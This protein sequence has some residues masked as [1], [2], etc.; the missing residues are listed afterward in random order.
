MKKLF[1]VL[2]LI[3]FIDVSISF[4]QASRLT[5]FNSI[6]WFVYVGD[7]QLTDKWAIHTEYQWRRVGWISQQQQ[8]L[9]R[10]GL[11][12]TLSER[13][14]VSGGYTYF[15]S[16]RYGTYPEVA[17]RPE[18]EHRI[19]QDVSLKD[20]LGKLQLTHRLRLEQRWLGSRNE[21][22][23]SPVQEWTYQNRIRYQISAEFP[24]QGSTTDDGE[25]YLNAFD[26]LFIGFGQAVEDNVFNQNR[27][28]GGIGYQFTEDAK[29]ELNYLYQIRQHATPDP[30]S[31]R[32]VVELNHGF[33]LNMIYN[34][35]LARK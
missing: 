24:L 33:R 21:R 34:L 4:G 23:D 6:G 26:E 29:L 2:S 32:S 31:N 14:D 28:S 13:I 3:C 25:W 18:P 5:N 12:R 15:Q 1:T 9:A 10:V 27:L 8:H 30:T 17:E 20:Q 35:N 19:Y 7:H 16:H 11:M 22:G